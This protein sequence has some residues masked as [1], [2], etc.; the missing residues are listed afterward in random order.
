VF[1]KL[2]IN[3]RKQLRSALPD[4]GHTAVPA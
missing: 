2:E 3:S 1:A 4:S